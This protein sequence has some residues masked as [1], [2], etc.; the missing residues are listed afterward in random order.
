MK[1]VITVTDEVEGGGSAAAGASAGAST[2]STV[3]WAGPTSPPTDS[4]AQ[5]RDGGG[6]FRQGE[7]MRQGIDGGA[8]PQ[9]LLEMS[10]EVDAGRLT[11]PG[12][13]R[14]ER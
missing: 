7:P 10:G 12:A 11:G 5:H 6:A 14:Y 9:F 4:T 3:T 2:G 1:L 8:A 13:M